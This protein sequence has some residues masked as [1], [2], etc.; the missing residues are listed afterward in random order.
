VLQLKPD[1]L[2]ALVSRALAWQGEGK[3]PEAVADL[4]R[5]IDL[6]FPET[7]IYFM[8]AEI[9]EKLGNR[10]DAERDRREGLQRVP[11]D[12]R[13]WVARGVARIDHEPEEALEDFRS[14]LALNSRDFGAWRNIAHTLSERLGR[15]QEAVEALDRLLQMTADDPGAW[16]G[17]GVLLARMGRAE[18]AR[19]DARQALAIRRDALTVYQA[20]CIEA[21]SSKDNDGAIHTALP[22]LAESLLKQVDLAELALADPDLER[23]RGSQIFRNLVAA[24]RFLVAMPGAVNP[25]RAERTSD[26]TAGN[27]K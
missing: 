7:R 24:A 14:A 17:R 20:A 26:P 6:G 10:Q 11:T 13:S 16:A 4:T 22:L 23:L 12:S 25:A 5:A 18:A 9:H 15:P 8:R 1:A 2:A 3:L 19:A 27:D 21:L